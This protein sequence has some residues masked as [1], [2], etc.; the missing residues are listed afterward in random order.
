MLRNDS[1]KVKEGDI[2]IAIKGSKEDGH[3]YVLDAIDNGAS[4]V[5][6]EYGTYP[7]MI[8]V[9]NTTEYLHSYV[10]KEYL[11]I[12]KDLKLI[13]ITGTNGKT[14]TAYLTYQA[15][16]KL[17]IK[18]AYIGTI[19]F[20]INDKKFGSLNTT[21][22]ILNLYQML[23]ECVKNDI[24]YVVL[25]VSSQGLY[26]N[27]VDGLTF[28]YAVFTNL[29]QDHLDFHQTMDNYLKEKQ[30]LF[31]LL[32]NDGIGIVNSDDSYHKSFITS[33]TV[34][35]GLNGEYK[36]SDIK[37]NLKNTSFKLNN[38]EYKINLVGKYNVYNMSVVIILLKL[39]KIN[40]EKIKNIIES[41]SSAPGRM[42]M[43]KYNDNL[44]VIDYAHTPDAVKKAIDA[45]KELGNV[46][47]IIGCGGNRD[48]SKRKIMGKIA[49]NNSSY[50]FFTS[51]NPRYEN[52]N[53][54]IFD[55]LQELDI[56][57]YEIEVNRKKAIL[58]GIQK[59]TKDD[60]LLILG[61]GHEDYQ[62]ISGV[63]YHFNDREIVL[64]KINENN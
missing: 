61:K 4:K 14:T 36:I 41:L 63:K 34:T 44:I 38:E 18:C 33:H 50:V 43:I 7:N 23:I 24:S 52:P 9:D 26:Y 49:S 47:T 1:R 15:L 10:K 2:F 54:I 60:I 22:D 42:D 64:E 27:R 31:Q 29:T 3:N 37:N 16:N 12:V 46:I 6:V 17:N 39:L 48:K 19:G 40:T 62:E 25:E 51:D 45:L 35:Y 56:F 32:K 57:N 13:G 20:Y 55:M 30:K 21:P 11:P 53:D 58:K 8:K 5:I 59:L 28:D